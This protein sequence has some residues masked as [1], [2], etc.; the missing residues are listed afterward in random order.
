MAF[1]PTASTVTFEARYSINGAQCENCLSFFIG[2]VP[3]STAAVNICNSY[4]QQVWLALRDLSTAD[5]IYREGYVTD[6]SSAEGPT[7]SQAATV[8][9]ASGTVLTDSVPNNAALV[10]SL[11]SESRGRSGRGRN[12]IAGL[13]EGLKVN[14]IWQPAPIA[15]LLAAYENLRAVLQASN[16]TM[17]VLSK[18][19]G[20]APRP[21]GATYI[22]T[23]F[24]NTTPA[25]RSQRRRNV[26]VGS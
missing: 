16:I 4:E 11:R 1:I 19:T 23:E 15:T 21:A 5:T 26:G 8:A 18:Q 10:I 13:A 6:Q 20:G 17:V 3:F 7:Y 9:T 2:A 25:V 14:S 22:V 12:Y 24:V